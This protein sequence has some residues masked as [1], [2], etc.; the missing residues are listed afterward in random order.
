MSTDPADQ[1]IYDAMKRLY[2]MEQAQSRTVNL[3]VGEVM[4]WL[5]KRIESNSEFLSM[6]GHLVPQEMT[7]EPPPAPP[8][9]PSPLPWDVEENMR[10]API[11]GPPP[12]P[13]SRPIQP[14]G[15]Y[16][17]EQAAVA[18]EQGR[19]FHGGRR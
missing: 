8:A 6:F 14:P 10:G 2:D 11:G 16:N 9:T 12:L 18:F 15:T 7:S 3:A 13:Q 19:A 17:D 5:Q 1:Q 4:S